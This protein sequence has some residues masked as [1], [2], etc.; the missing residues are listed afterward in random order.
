MS[1]DADRA[2]E[3]ILCL[4]ASGVTAGLTEDQLVASLRALLTN[5]AYATRIR[6]YL[7]RAPGQRSAQAAHD[8]LAELATMVGIDLTADPRIELHPPVADGLAGILST[9]PP[10]AA[11]LLFVSAGILVPPGWDTRLRAVAA[12]DPRIGGISPLCAG[13][14]PFAERSPG[15]SIAAWLLKEPPIRIEDWLRHDRL[16]AELG[17]D[18]HPQLPLLLPVC[19]YLSGDAIAALRD[20]GDTHPVQLE[21]AGLIS[22]LAINLLV[23]WDPRAGGGERLSDYLAAAGHD[24]ERFEWLRRALAEPPRDPSRPPAH[25]PAQLHITHSWGGGLGHW[26]DDFIQGDDTRSNLVLKSIGSWDAF[27]QRLELYATYTDL[28]PLRV[29]SLTLPIQSTALAQL[30]YGALLREIVA[31]YGVQ[32]ILVSSLIGHSLDALSTGL[33]TLLIAHDHYPF[34]ITLYAYFNG[35]CEDCD[36]VRLRRCIAE[37]PGH[38]FFRNRSAEDWEALRRAF[39]HSLHVNPVTLVAPA[40]SVLTRWQRQMPAL[41]GVPA[42]VIPHGLGLPPSPPLAGTDHERLRLVIPGKLSWAK[43]LSLL[44]RALPV[45]GE[46]ADVHLL[47][48]GIEGRPFARIPGIFIIE[49]YARG[50]FDAELTLIRPHLGL[51]SSL[52][53]E[54]FSYTL[55]ELNHYGIPVLATRV[56][57]FVDRIEEDATGFFHAPDAESLIAAVRALDANRDRLAAV[58]DRLRQAPA[59]DLAAMVSDYHTLLPLPPVGA[60]SLGLGQPPQARDAEIL[61][62]HPLATYA[63]ALRAFARYSMAKLHQSPRLPPWM[64]I[65]LPLPSRW[66]RALVRR[67]RPRLRR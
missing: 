60:P 57:S 8:R 17:A 1:S 54:T 35:V 25:R 12:L 33:P 56:G 53:P 52:V 11:E 43:G 55:S 44:E 36:G 41:S 67:L 22:L 37:N 42:R 65:L 46:F 32:A 20:T 15:H 45:L 62:V 3:R 21:R 51:L 16:I 4:D 10:H 63:M 58:R 9:L 7:P 13:L 29:W 48:C 14:P 19:C 26:V 24:S 27:G 34:C 5:T 28:P 18:R 49:H 23:A 61:Y 40:T 47:G 64:R 38:G 30:E 31:D 2:V 6:L 59:R 66:S 50:Q 39:V